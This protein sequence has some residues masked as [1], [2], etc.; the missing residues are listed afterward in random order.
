ML[1]AGG[2][3]R[4]GSGTPR[5]AAAAAEGH[6]HVNHYDGHR[7]FCTCDE[8]KQ[9]SLLSGHTWNI[10]N[11]RSDH[12][13]YL[14][15]ARNERHYIDAEGRNTSAWFERKGRVDLDGDNVIDTVDSS[16][17]QEVLVCPR[18]AGKEVAHL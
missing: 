1:P 5:A 11:N 10:L 6:E 2:G 4:G 17:V 15:H 7:T 12:E 14:R 18:T 16:N 9:A 3:P 13:V 8:R